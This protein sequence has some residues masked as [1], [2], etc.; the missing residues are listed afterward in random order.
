MNFFR[1]NTTLSHLNVDR[2]RPE[3]YLLE[4]FEEPLNE[5]FT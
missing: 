5:I 2:E 3:K 4:V 1:S